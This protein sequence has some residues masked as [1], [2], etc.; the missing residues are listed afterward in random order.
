MTI[1]IFSEFP[2]SSP[3]GNLLNFTVMTNQNKR[4][5]TTIIT[6]FVL[7]LTPLAAGWFTIG[8]GGSNVSLGGGGG[9]G[10]NDSEICTDDNDLVTAGNMTAQAS[11]EACDA[12]SPS[13][14]DSESIILDCA[15]PSDRDTDDS[16]ADFTTVTCGTGDGQASSDYY[17]SN[18]IV[19]REDGDT[20]TELFDQ[21]SIECVVDG[22]D[23]GTLDEEEL[24]IS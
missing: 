16:T 12:P 24:I 9:G 13:T 3:C 20:D 7:F 18:G 5:F 2:A 6:I 14:A 11:G 23:N 4:V 17:C 19:F 10:S 15:S 8:C 21:T 22:D 1:A